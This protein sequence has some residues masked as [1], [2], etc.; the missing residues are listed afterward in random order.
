M[1]CTLLNF[2]QFYSE[3]RHGTTCG[4]T[5]CAL[6]DGGISYI[7]LPV[8]VPASYRLCIGDVQFVSLA[9]WTGASWR[10]L[11]VCDVTFVWR[12]EQTFSFLN[13]MYINQIINSCCRGNTFVLDRRVR[14]MQRDICPFHVVQSISTQVESRFW[15]NSKYRAHNVAVNHQQATRSDPSRVLC[16]ANR[17]MAVF[18]W[19][20]Q[21]VEHSVNRDGG[22]DSHQIKTRLHTE[23]GTKVPTE[24][25]IKT[26]Q[27]WLRQ[28]HNTQWMMCS[29]NGACLG[30]FTV[31]GR[32]KDSGF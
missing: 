12:Y 2:K 10:Q 9:S 1:L 21:H 4:W 11:A 18:P 6:S 29:K 22:P 3:W 25:Q 24:W 20:G 31:T 30:K 14:W 27:S 13:R 7:M 23:L 15:S 17:V 8:I 28:L 16:S 32:S 5:H 19:A 26:R